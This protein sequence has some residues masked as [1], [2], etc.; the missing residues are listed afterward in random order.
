MMSSGP[1]YIPGVQYHRNFILSGNER[2]AF[3]PSQ[4]SLGLVNLHAA[5]I[6]SVYRDGHTSIH[7][8]LS[9]LKPYNPVRAAI[10]RLIV[11]D[12]QNSLASS[13]QFR[14]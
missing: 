12:H 8:N 11:A 10:V 5:N 2:E 7:L 13:L 4:I 9:V 14:Q 1:E 3:R 6:G